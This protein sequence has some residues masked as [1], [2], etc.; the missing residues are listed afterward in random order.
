M[1]SVM[2]QSVLG[3]QPESPV[4]VTQELAFLTQHTGQ[5]ELSLLSQALHLGLNLLYR[6]TAEKAFIDGALARPEAIA[7]LGAQRVTEIEYA[8][9]A[10]AEDV[11]RGLG[12]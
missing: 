4:Q 10:L 1:Q 9:Q 11:A 2:S 8:K 6:Q 7:A 5:D 12:R 3:D